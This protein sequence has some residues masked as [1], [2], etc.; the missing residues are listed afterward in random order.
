MPWRQIRPYVSHYAYG[1][2]DAPPEGW[3]ER[4]V[5][6]TDLQG[7]RVGPDNPFRYG[8]HLRLRTSPLWQAARLSPEFRSWAEDHENPDVRFQAWEMSNVRGEPAFGL[9]YRFLNDGFRG[10]ITPERRE[11]G[12]GMYAVGIMADCVLVT[13]REN[14]AFSSVVDILEGRDPETQRPLATPPQGPI[15]DEDE[16]I[17]GNLSL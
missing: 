10:P 14:H 8:D 15:P 2:R 11:M 5:W 13:S 12:Y 3:S 6:V 7:P 9:I 4:R 16:E 1:Q 17:L